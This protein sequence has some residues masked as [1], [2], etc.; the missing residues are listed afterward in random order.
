L[1]NLLPDELFYFAF[2]DQQNENP[3]EKMHA[4]RGNGVGRERNTKN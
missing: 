4:K 1:N 3:V 2:M